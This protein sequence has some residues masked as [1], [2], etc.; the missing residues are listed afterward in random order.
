MPLAFWCRCMCYHCIASEWA[1][2]NLWVQWEV[3]I[4]LYNGG[5][6]DL[7]KSFVKTKKIEVDS[8]W[9]KHIPKFS[10][11]DHR[12]EFLKVFCF[13]GLETC[14][15]ARWP[16]FSLWK[17]LHML[18]G[19][20]DS[21]ILWVIVWHLT[22]TVPF[23]KH[24]STPTP[25]INETQNIVFKSFFPLWNEVRILIGI[26]VSLWVLFS[27]TATFVELI[28]WEASEGFP[29]SLSYPSLYFVLSFDVLKVHC[30]GLSFPGLADSI[31]PSLLNGSASLIFSSACLLLIHRKGI[32]FC[33]LVLYP[34][35]FPKSV[36]QL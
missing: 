1:C 36:Y 2:E 8:V 31:T 35:N 7:M 6:Q 14:L 27:S 4:S 11:Q 23:G 32:D 25:K 26:T 24:A 21:R 13:S 16:E 28:P 3:R 29:S 19:S 33:L 30:K 5:L 22:S 34:A 15:Q 17:G 12:T 18:E 10:T 9:R 20:I